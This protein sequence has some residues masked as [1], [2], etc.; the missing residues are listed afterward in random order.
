MC[1]L[2]IWPLTGANAGSILD[3]E[4]RLGNR[5]TIQEVS[6]GSD[7]VVV[8]TIGGDPNLDL[9]FDPQKRKLSIVDHRNRTFMPITESQIEKL[10][11]H[12]EDIAPLVNGLGEQ[13]RHLDPAH[14]AKWERM[15]G[16]APLDAFDTAK[17]ELKHFS[18]KDTHKLHR[19]GG[20]DCRAFNLRSDRMGPSSICVIGPDTLGLPEGES[21]SIRQLISFMHA[22]LKKAHRVA[23]NF[24]AVIASDAIEQLSGIPIEIKSNTPKARVSMELASIRLNQPSATMSWPADYKMVDFKLW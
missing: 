15:I 18:I 21:Q 9:Y 24:G 6:V 8:K 10:A 17:K 4:V 20:F 5:R 7:Q 1:L 22:L 16:G 23:S 13:I 3:Y 11:G 19:V 2:L 14:K 12:I